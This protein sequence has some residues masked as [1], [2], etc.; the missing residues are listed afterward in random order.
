MATVRG[1]QR[2]SIGAAVLFNDWSEPLYNA[3]TGAPAGQAL[4]DRRGYWSQTATGLTSGR[5][6]FNYFRAVRSETVST[7][8]AVCGGTAAGATPTLV[9]FG[10]YTEATNGDLTLVASTASDT[11]LFGTINAQVTKALQASYGLIQGQRYAFTWL[12]VTGA[13][14][15]VPLQRGS[16]GAGISAELGR[17][18]KLGSQVSGQTDLPS[19]VAVGSL[20]DYGLVMYSALV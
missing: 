10:L 13:A 1:G 3:S 14:V 12:V 9:R 4:V 17:G 6:A 16:S 8:V 20:A 11:S 18:Y 2:S 5:C 7:A 15:P 19:S